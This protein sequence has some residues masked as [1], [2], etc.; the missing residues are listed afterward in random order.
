[1]EFLSLGTSDGETKLKGI[2]PKFINIFREK[3]MEFIRGWPEDS[4]QQRLFLEE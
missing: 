1:M 3:F 2:H 4:E